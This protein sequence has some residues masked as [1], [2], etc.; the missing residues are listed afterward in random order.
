[1]SLGDACGG[2]AD[3]LQKRLDQVIVVLGSRAAR[4]DQRAGL[5]EVAGLDAQLAEVLGVLGDR[6]V[7]RRPGRR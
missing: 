1:M 7:R 4:Q 2:L 5:V 3:A 6:A